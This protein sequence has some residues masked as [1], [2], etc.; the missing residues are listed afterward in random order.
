[1]APSVHQVVRRR[2]V[3][4]IEGKTWNHPVVIGDILLVRNGQAMAAFRLPA[5][6]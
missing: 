1:M 5:A 4:N 6:R 3:V 2:A